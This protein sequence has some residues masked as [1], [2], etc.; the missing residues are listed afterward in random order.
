[1]NEPKRI[2]SRT[3]LLTGGLGFIGTAL[4]GR[5]RAAGHE[6]VV[7]DN[8]HPQ[9]HRDGV[10]SEALQGVTL[11]VG[12]VADLTLMTRCV[13]EVRPDVV[14]HLA[15]ETGTGQSVTEPVRHASVNGVGTA[16][17]I[18]AL[19]ACRHVPERIVLPSSRAVYGEGQ[20][21]SSTGEL[22][23]AV[24][25]SST[26]LDQG[27]WGVEVPGG[28]EATFV[29]HRAQ[30]TLPNP[31]SVYGATKLLQE[32]LLRSF[33]DHADSGLT[34]LRL[35]NVFGPGQAPDNPYTGIVMHFLKLAKAGL[36]IEVY[37]DGNITRDFVHVS[38]VVG[39]LLAAVDRRVDGTVDIGSGAPLSVRSVAALIAE[40]LGAPHPV[41]TGAYRAGDVRAAAADIRAAAELLGYAART[42]FE[43]GLEDLLA[44]D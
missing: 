21:R 15:A 9:V 41:V 2:G 37:E 24:P 22:F 35:Q 5:L 39:A 14:V 23:Y 30:E 3:W 26:R 16:C 11:Y 43:T 33:S 38:D 27:R 1:M 29:A 12:D 32:H 31:A 13:A 20:W 6:V 17:L 19:H 7:L 44:S 8:I 40:R 25:R 42:T 34:I 18:H 10:P 28:G 4:A 36:T